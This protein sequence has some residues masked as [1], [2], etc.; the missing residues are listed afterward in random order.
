MVSR[1]RDCKKRT[2]F[3]DQAASIP[4]FFRFYR[5]FVRGGRQGQYGACG[6]HLSDP[7]LLMIPGLERQAIEDLFSTDSWTVVR[8]AQTALQK[9]GSL[10]AK[11][12]LFEA[13]SRFHEETP[14]GDSDNGMEYGFVSA[15]LKGNG[16]VPSSTDINRAFSLCSKDDCRNRVENIR[17]MLIPPLAISFDLSIN[18]LDYARVGPFTVGSP[19]QLENKISQFSIGTQF[20]LERYY[21]G[22]WY[23]ENQ[24]QSIQRMLITHGMELVEAPPWPNSSA[25]SR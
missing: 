7:Y 24:M 16:W 18:G 10:I 2:H 1:Y 19:Q 21:E 20:Y 11:E 3:Y 4:G 23:R 12:P 25:I 8:M 17:S 13:M 14:V 22:T 9:G 5:S 6:I 15:L